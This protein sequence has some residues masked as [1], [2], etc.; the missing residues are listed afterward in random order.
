M[1]NGMA[2]ERYNGLLMVMV[3]VRDRGC[4]TVFCPLTLRVSSLLLINLGTMDPFGGFSDSLF[5]RKGTV[6]WPGTRQAIA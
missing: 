2:E 5:P 1:H 6:S 3:R 4:I